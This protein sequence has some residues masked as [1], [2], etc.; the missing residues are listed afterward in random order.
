MKKSFLS[1]AIFLCSLKSGFSDTCHPPIDGSKQN[2]IIGYGSLVND[3][4]RQRTNPEAVNAYP[5]EVKNFKRIWGLRATGS[6]KGTFLLA[7]PST[8]STLNAVYYLT[9][10]KAVEA[11][12]K[13]ESDYCRYKVPS[14]DVEALGLKNLQQG[15]YWIYARDAKAIQKPNEEFPIIQSYVDIFIKGCMEIQNR[16][17]VANYVQQ[18]INTTSLWDNNTWV[19]DRVNPRRPTDSTPD[20]IAIDNALVRHLGID[21]YTHKYE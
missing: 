19:N 15:D 20:A 12:D 11:T 6:F 17:L 1:L 13:R 3:K 18:C 7:V 16:Y 9:N 14:T 4:S 8:G 5:I 21:Y 2:F 10:E